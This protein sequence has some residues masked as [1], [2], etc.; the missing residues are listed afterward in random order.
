MAD[1]EH[2]GLIVSVDAGGVAIV[3]S[4]ESHKQYPFNFDRISNY[5]GQQAREIG[6]RK[7]RRVRFFTSADDSIIAVEIIPSS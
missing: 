7:G 3:E 4:T 2:E 5:G 6:L 1:Q